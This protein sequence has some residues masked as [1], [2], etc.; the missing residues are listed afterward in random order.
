MLCL[1]KN[2]VNTSDQILIDILVSWL[3]FNTYNFYFKFKKVQTP[4]LQNKKFPS[5][6]SWKNDESSNNTYYNIIHFLTYC[7]V[8][9]FFSQVSRRFCID[10]RQLPLFNK[11]WTAKLSSYPCTL[12]YQ[13]RLQKSYLNQNF[14][15]FH[16]RCKHKKSIF[17]GLLF[18]WC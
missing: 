14:L 11:L 10:G 18:S 6:L 8:A 2:L 15:I 1:F 12:F 16:C 17:I 7:F 9:I 13:I 3:N 5:T 4:I